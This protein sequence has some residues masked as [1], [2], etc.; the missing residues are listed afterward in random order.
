MD[1]YVQGQEN[2]EKQFVA[3]PR[4][5]DYTFYNFLLQMGTTTMI[6]IYY[7]AYISWLLQ[8]VTTNRYN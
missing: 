7:T 1:L 6:Y 2:E 4:K 3:Q 8:L 5:L